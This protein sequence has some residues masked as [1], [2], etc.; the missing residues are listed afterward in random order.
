MRHAPI[1]ETRAE[2]PTQEQELTDQNSAQ[3]IK[4]KV[5][6]VTGGTRGI[7]RAIATRLSDAGATVIVCGRSAP[8]DL[9]ES[10]H[11][12]ACDIRD[13]EAA[14]T[15]VDGVADRFGRLDILINNAGGSPEAE[16]A[17]ASPR[18]AE[19][20][21]ALN[22]LAPLNLS[23][24]AYAHMQAA[25]GG[26][27]VNIASVS[28]LRPSPGTTAYAAAKAGLLALGRSLAHEWGP[29]IRVNAI[30]VGYIETESTEATYGNEAAQAAI[31]A[32][33]GAQRLGRAS[34]I[35]EAAL[36]LVSPAA[37]YVTGAALNVDGGGERPP[38][39]DILK[40]QNS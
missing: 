4:D 20:V 31:A 23:Q 18:F 30:V 34:E 9:P 2:C 37:S 21:I 6:I 28:A 11:F 36:F 35:A 13:P 12:V 26:A 39:L 5:A 22:L 8:D 7:G 24:A 15:F 14:K 3:P 29:A 10:L 17:T 38:F 1:V 33:I 40:E 27:I 16:A 19:R 32:N 25:G